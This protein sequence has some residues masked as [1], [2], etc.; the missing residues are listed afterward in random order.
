VTELDISTLETAG[1]PNRTQDH[2]VLKV[3][4]HAQLEVS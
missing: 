4:S 2:R 1:G 3:V